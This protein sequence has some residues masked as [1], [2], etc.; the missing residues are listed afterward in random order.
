M[1]SAV[2][3]TVRAWD[4]SYRVPH[5]TAEQAGKAGRVIGLLLLAAGLV[6][7]GGIAYEVIQ[8]LREVKLIDLRMVLE[9]VSVGDA[10]LTWFAYVF[11]REL[12]RIFA[13]RDSFDG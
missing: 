2:H 11:G 7:C 13:A 1:R 6:Y 9:R 10:I 12:L 8:S 4:G 3:Q 5:V